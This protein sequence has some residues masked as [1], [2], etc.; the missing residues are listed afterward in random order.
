VGGRDGVEF[1]VC[2]ELRACV[3]AR[4][5][6]CV[7]VGCGLVCVFVCVCGGGGMDACVHEIKSG[8]RLYL[9]MSQC[10]LFA[11]LVKEEG[12]GFLR[13]RS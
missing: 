4:V 6:V 13:K 12:C 8:M 9:C 11:A 5:C 1:W 2:A 10:L 3:R 7:G